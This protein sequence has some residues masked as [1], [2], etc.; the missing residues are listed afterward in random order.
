EMVLA[1]AARDGVVPKVVRCKAEEF[2]SDALFKFAFSVNVMEH[3]EAPDA[4]IERVSASL[5]PGGSYR[6]LCPNYLFPYEPHFNIP[7]F[8]SKRLTER[9]LRRRIH[10]NTRA[11]D[12]TGLWKSLNWITV[13]QVKRMAAADPS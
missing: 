7:T 10:S 3:I 1:L 4:A 9:L 11:N 6:F 5:A 8:G 2:R 13:P 12:P